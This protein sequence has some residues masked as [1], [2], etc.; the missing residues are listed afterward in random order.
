MSA[1]LSTALVPSPK[2]DGMEAYTRALI[3][4]LRSHKDAMLTELIDIT[5]SFW[6]VAINTV[7]YVALHLLLC[8]AMIL[9]LT[10]R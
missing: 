3:V 5:L 1:N 10:T 9:V 7:L 6:E 4:E 2:T 8:H